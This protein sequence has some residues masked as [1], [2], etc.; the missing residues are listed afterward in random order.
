MKSNLKNCWWWNKGKIEISDE[1]RD[2]MYIFKVYKLYVWW[3]KSINALSTLNNSTIL[4]CFLL[5]LWKH[6]SFN[7]ITNCWFIDLPHIL[8]SCSVK[9]N[10]QQCLPVPRFYDINSGS[11]SLKKLYRKRNQFII[12]LAVFTN[13]EIV[14]FIIN[15][16]NKNIVLSGK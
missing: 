2:Y 8:P 9:P 16:L 3:N 12:S 13:F 1:T 15:Q 14:H 11:G 7:E 5:R 4:G 10:T 6:Y